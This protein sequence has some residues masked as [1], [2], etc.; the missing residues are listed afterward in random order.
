MQQQKGNRRS[1][2]GAS[3]GRRK[4]WTSRSRQSLGLCH[5][6]EYDEYLK[7][8]LESKL[9]QN[10]IRDV[11]TGMKKITGFKQKDDQSDGTEPVLSFSAQPTSASS[12]CYYEKN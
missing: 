3:L 5:L 12:L 7:K 6:N 8:K 10:N 1:S 9:Q 4:Q 2:S 11:W